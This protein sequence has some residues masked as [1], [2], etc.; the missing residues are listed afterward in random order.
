M[1]RLVSVSAPTVSVSD[2]FAADGKA[3]AVLVNNDVRPHDG[4]VTVADG[5]R[6]VSVRT[7]RPDLVKL[8]SGRL[9][10]APD[11]GVLVELAR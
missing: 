11:T 2:H 8:E 3:Y 1:K 7:D 5:W 9:H 6:I 4:P 10:M